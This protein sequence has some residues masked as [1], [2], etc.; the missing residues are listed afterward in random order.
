MA[1]PDSTKHKQKKSEEEAENVAHVVTPD[2]D[3]DPGTPKLGLRKVDA[4]DPATKP[5]RRANPEPNEPMHVGV[6]FDS[7]ED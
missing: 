6:N 4:R 5:K 1:E 2:P 7:R 3:E